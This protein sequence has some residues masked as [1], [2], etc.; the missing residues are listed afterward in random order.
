MAFSC[1]FHKKASFVYLFHMSTME[2]RR[3]ELN[4][5]EWYSVSLTFV[6]HETTFTMSSY[7]PSARDKLSSR[8][9]AMVGGGEF[10][11]QRPWPSYCP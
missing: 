8:V 3:Q 11:L 6:N 7:L 5:M 1:N 2:K 9:L 10:Q 4:M